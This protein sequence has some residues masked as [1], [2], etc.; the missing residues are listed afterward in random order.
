V[1]NGYGKEG[2]KEAPA[3]LASRSFPQEEFR[4]K[5]VSVCQLDRTSLDCKLLYQRTLGA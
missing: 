1:R 5:T 2:K 3:E 4:I